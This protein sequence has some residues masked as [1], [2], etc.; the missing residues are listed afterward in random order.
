MQD[1]LL[2]QVAVGHVVVTPVRYRIELQAVGELHLVGFA[3]LLEL[4]PSLALPLALKRPR[5]VASFLSGEFVELESLLGQAGA[6]G[7]KAVQD[8]GCVRK[9]KKRTS[10]RSAAA[11]R[12]GHS[13]RWRSRSGARTALGVQPETIQAAGDWWVKGW[14]KSWLFGVHLNRAVTCI[15]RPRESAR[16]SMI[17]CPRS[18]TSRQM[19][20]T[21]Q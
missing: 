9:E 5:W 14:C 17:G 6:V 7:C 3:K 13:C 10:M 2:L 19:H 12:L 8:G 21:I 16:A 15:Q 4:L 1:V 20:T 11:G 18:H